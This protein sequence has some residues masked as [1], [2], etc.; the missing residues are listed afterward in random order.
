MRISHFHLISTLGGNKEYLFIYYLI[1]SYARDPLR[2]TP[3]F[4][5]SMCILRGLPQLKNPM[6]RELP[7]F[8]MFPCSHGNIS[9]LRNQKERELFYIR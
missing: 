5:S 4:I 6:P 9:F 7:R 8:I 3:F 1:G 2:T